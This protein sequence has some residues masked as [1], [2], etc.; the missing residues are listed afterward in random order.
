MA[1]RKLNYVTVPQTTDIDVLRNYINQALENIISDINNQLQVKDYNGQRL[2]NIGDPVNQS[3]AATKEYVDLKIDEL[4]IGRRQRKPG[5]RIVYHF[6]L[7]PGGATLSVANDVTNHI[8][9][10]YTG[11]FVGASFCAKTAPSGADCIL[12][13]EKSSD[14]GSSWTSI[15]PTGSSNKIV[16]PSGSDSA[17]VKGPAFFDTANGH[18]TEGDLLRI[19]VIQTGSTTTDVLVRLYTLPAQVL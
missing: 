13:V 3:D 18:V 7:G 9:V 4:G 11:R 17:I 6:V 5:N 19:N 2:T 12:D 15:F 16:I 14:S 1:S 10:A 8:G